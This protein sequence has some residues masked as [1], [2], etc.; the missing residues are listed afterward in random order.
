[1][2]RSLLGKVCTVCLIAWMSISL[3]GCGSKVS[4]KYV[5]GGGVMTID[6]ESGKATV[7]S[8]MLGNTDSETADYT[9][10]GDT[11]TIKIKDGDM[12][13]TIMKD[14]S[15]QGNGITLTKSAG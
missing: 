11:V 2:F 10:N 13:L 15:L 14:G 8:Q 7:T 9:V 1:M 12:N 4:G 6:F 3:A 5:G